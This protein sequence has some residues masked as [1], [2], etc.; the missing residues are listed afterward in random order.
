MEEMPTNSYQRV[1]CLVQKNF[2]MQVSAICDV[3][4]RAIYVP[5]ML[6]HLCGHPE[7]W[8][9]GLTKSGQSYILMGITVMKQ[10]CPLLRSM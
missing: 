10:T 4:G 9:L 7:G 1:P 6:V 8:T 2:H 5:T 3:F